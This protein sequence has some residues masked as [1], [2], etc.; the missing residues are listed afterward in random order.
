[1]G[2]IEKEYKDFEKIEQNIKK[3]YDKEKQDKE[4][5]DHNEQSGNFAKISLLI[6]V[7]VI[8]CFVITE[9]K[10]PGYIS[11][12]I[13]NGKD[14]ASDFAD[15]ISDYEY[16]GNS[17]GNGNDNDNG[18]GHQQNK[19]QYPTQ[20]TTKYKPP[21][22]KLPDNIKEYIDS[23]YDTTF[24]LY[25]NDKSGRIVHHYYDII[26]G[27]KI[28]RKC[29][30]YYVNANKYVLATIKS[31]YDEETR[32]WDTQ[33][34]IYCFDGKEI[35]SFETEP[36]KLPTIVGDKNIYPIWCESVDNY[37]R[38]SNINLEPLNMYMDEKKKSSK[39]HTFSKQEA[40]NLIGYTPE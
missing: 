28:T 9:I 8:A 6:I 17:N 4:R 11:N 15:Y 35:E 33:S 40:F 26:N 39:N 22:K 14:N 29:G 2:K 7:T 32:L 23:E 3:K 12:L 5:H 20:N 16:N 38:F 24:E 13:Q 25:Y 19:I 34:W 1:M 21:Q 31:E 10:N 27:G 36:E 37:T 18:N 30:N